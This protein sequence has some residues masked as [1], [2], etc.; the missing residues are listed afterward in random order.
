MK[1]APCLILLIASL[2]A[3]AV[4]TTHVVLPE[5]SIQAKIDV[6][7][8]GDIIAI[9]GGTYSQD[10]T[11]NKA[12]RL[13]EVKGEEVTI[14]GNVTF[15]AVT[16][17]PPFQGLTVGGP[18]KGIIV[19]DSG[20]L[21]IRNTGNTGNSGLGIKATG[22][23]VVFVEGG[24]PDAITA[25]GARMEV[26]NATVTGGVSQGGAWL[27]IFNSIVGGSVSQSAGK[28]NIASSTVGGLSST[29]S[30]QETCCFRLVS[31]GDVN[32][33]SPKVWFGYSKAR[34]FGFSGSNAKVAVIGSEIDGGKSQPIG[35]GDYAFFG[36]ILAG[37]SNQYAIA[38]SVIKGVPWAWKGGE[39]GIRCAGVGHRISILNNW[40]DFIPAAR[41]WREYTGDGIKVEGNPVA[42]RIL[43]NII[44]RAGYGLNA[45]F[46][47]VDARNNLMWALGD[48]AWT[49]RGGVAPVDTLYADPLA[50]VGTPPTL[51]AGSPCINAGWTNPIFNDL[52]G[53]R[54]DIGPSGGCWYDPSGW[55]TEKPVV[56]S[57]DLAPEQVLGG[58]DPE[59]ILSGGK[60]VS[61]P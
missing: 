8:P 23:S 44:T 24:S 50:V 43:N 35:A 39:V 42:C 59:V 52:D 33:A 12:V 13:V 19:N 4:P 5:E 2:P 60:A 21:L 17:P 38:N 26:S 1:L 18:N 34:S 57:Y 53:T 7:V 27:D 30:A 9:F 56:I 54:N 58:D 20:P 40:L 31:T 61:Q 47:V 10:V 6:A 15:A 41:Y 11:V 14:T 48:P 45:P 3:A 37:T 22:T 49:H 51:Q 32:L 28:L 25:N 36:M 29:G 46:G 55:T 16:D